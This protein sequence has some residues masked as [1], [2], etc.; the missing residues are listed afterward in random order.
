MAARNAP[1]MEPIPPIII[2]TNATIII[3]LPIPMLASVIGEI[4]IPAKPAIAAPTANTTVKSDLMSI[5]W[6]D[7]I[8]LFDAPARISIPILVW[9]IIK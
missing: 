7:T 1:L 3:S 8:C 2:T 9:V 5:P 4:I 6:A